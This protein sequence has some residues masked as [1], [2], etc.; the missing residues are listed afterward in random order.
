[1]SYPWNDSKVKVVG[2]MIDTNMFRPYDGYV[3]DSPPLFIS[4]GRISPIKDILTLV[5]AAAI[6]R[7][8]GFDFTCVL[9]GPELPLD[10]EYAARVRSEIKVLGL[11]SYFSFIG[12]LTYREMPDYY[13]RAF[14]HINASPLGAFD[15]AALEAAASGTL[16]VAANPA[17][18]EFFGTW[19][20]S[21]CFE[22]G[23]PESLADRISALL[24]K[25]PTALH[26]LRN[27]IRESVCRS[28][29][30]EAF[31]VRFWEVTDIIKKIS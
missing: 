27:G 1:M 24:A 16:S 18:G 4:V 22:Y 26:D 31:M 5:R 21:L 14:L 13:R 2:Q 6:M 28:A 23:N 9:I 12:A 19:A 15:K 29:G 25:S 10:R 17:I 30:I 11:T 20:E 7:K 3:P 8:R